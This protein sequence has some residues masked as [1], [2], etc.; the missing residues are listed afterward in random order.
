MILKYI[1]KILKYIKKILN[2]FKEKHERI[3]NDLKDI[4][5]VLFDV[6]FAFLA[7]IIIVL[8][9]TETIV[10]YNRKVGNYNIGM[11]ELIN[12]DYYDY[13]NNPNLEHGELKDFSVSTNLVSFKNFGTESNQNG[14]CAGIALFEKFNYMSELKKVNSKI[15]ESVDLKEISLSDKE[16][17]VMY[18][19][20]QPVKLDKFYIAYSEQRKNNDA[21]YIVKYHLGE[22]TNSDF[23]SKIE[24]AKKAEVLNT[25]NL[26]A[27]NQF[28]YMK[29]NF[30]ENRSTNGSELVKS[31]IS[32]VAKNTDFRIDLNY[33]TSM[34][35][36]DEPVVVGIG[37]PKDGH[38]V[39][40]YKYE[41]IDKN[42]VKLYVYDPNMPF[43]EGETG[44]ESNISEDIKNN[45]FILFNR[46]DEKSK[47]E[48]IYNPRLNGSYIYRGKY[49]SFVEGTTMSIS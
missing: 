3:Y 6:A 26:L 28:D 21:E 19:K 44:D 48:F 36:E 17:E 9:I 39:L 27:T 47:W 40:G 38:A 10:N 15:D 34:I 43:P 4:L 8:I 16:I 7:I 42:T 5:V 20:I 41:Y 37:T 31:I 46:A 14:V 33:I 1:K 49:N 35:K 13:K 18:G 23:N 11:N 22:K 12:L 32:S 2:K 30:M 24:D 25:I 29:K 45:M